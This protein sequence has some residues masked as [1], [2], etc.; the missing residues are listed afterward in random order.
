MK[1]RYRKLSQETKQRISNSL[2]GKSKSNQH[3]AAISKEMKKYW[4]S[5]PDGEDENNSI[6]SLTNVEE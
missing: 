2:K 5:I 1:R 6:N 4:S 3:R